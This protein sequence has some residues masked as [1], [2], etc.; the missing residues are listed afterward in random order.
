MDPIS[1]ILAALAASGANVA[2]EAVKDAYAGL[3]ALILRK[4]GE[5]EPRL[6]ARIDEYVADADSFEKPAR[7]ALEAAGAAHDQEVLDVAVQ[8]LKQAE[9]AQPGVSGGL[10]GK[11]EAQGGNVMVAQHVEGGVWFGQPPAR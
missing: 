10:V 6:E 2:G 1:V 3:K 8:V 4:L 9:Q 7:K 5:G 11:I